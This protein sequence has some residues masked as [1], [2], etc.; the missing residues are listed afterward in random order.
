MESRRER[1]EQ[2]RWRRE[3][4]RRLEELDRADREHGVGPPGPSGPPGRS[5]RQ[6]RAISPVLPGLLI[7]G[8]LAGLVM[9]H[10]PGMTGYRFRQL[11]DHVS[12]HDSGSYA[13]MATTAAGDPVGWDH[14]RPIPYVVN[15]PVHPSAGRTSSRRRRPG[16]TDASGFQFQYDGTSI[17]RSFGKRTVDPNDPP[18]V[19][20]AWADSDEVPELAGATAGIGGSTPVRGSTTTSSTSPARSS[21]TPT[22]STAWTAGVTA[23]RGADPGPRARPRAR[24]GPRRRRRRAD[25]RRVRRPGRLRPRRPVGLSAAPRPA[26]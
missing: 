17:E 15:P 4:L 23:V 12:G 16:I 26:V 10:D 2:R 13:F 14:C 18:P 19:L 1:R 25:E 22:P 3:A 9:L 6:R 11:V 8:L 5:R 7:S 24:A 20:V 21:S